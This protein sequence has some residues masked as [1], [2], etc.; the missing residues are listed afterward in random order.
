MKYLYLFFLLLAC[1]VTRAQVTT[2]YLSGTIKTSKGKLAGGTTIL[3]TNTN[4]GGVYNSL[5]D[6][7]GNYTIPNLKPGGPYRID[8]SFK[9]Y[10]PLGLN[11]VIV[12]ITTPLKIDIVLNANSKNVYYVIVNGSKELV[13]KT[14]TAGELVNVTLKDLTY[15]PV[16]GGSFQDFAR[17]TPQANPI[18]STANNG[19]LGAS[20]LGQNTKYNL[21]SIDGIKAVNVFGLYSGGANVNPI[22]Q[23]SI[24]SLQV[25]LNPYDVFYGRFLGGYLSATTKSGTNYLHGEGY[26]YFQDQQLV[27]KSP[28]TGLNYPNFINRVLGASLGGPV[29]KNKLFFFADVENS[30]YSSPVIYDPTQANA[31]SKFDPTVLQGLHDY[32]EKQYGFD[33]GSY[34]GINRNISSTSAFGRLD[35][36]IDSKN[37][38]TLRN[39]YVE[40]RNFV[41]SRAPTSLTFSNDGYTVNIKTNSTVLEL[42]SSFSNDLS[43]VFRAG[44][45]YVNN[46][47]GTSAFPS[48]NITEGGLIYNLG[49]DNS[50]AANSL[51]QKDFNLVDYFNIYKGR[52]TLSFGTDNELYA[53]RSVF[54]QNYNG[55]YTY[56]SVAAFESGAA[57]A[58]YSVGYSTSGGTDKAPAVMR[59]A[60]LA[61]YS[62]DV[63][64]VNDR[65]KL[66][67]GIRVDMPVFLNSPDNNPAFNS[68]S[69]A[70]ANGVAT[71]RTPKPA[72]L[73]SPR[74]GFNY[75]L[76]GNQTTQLRGGAGVFTG[77]VPYVW[78]ANQYSNSGTRSISFTGVP[79]GLTFNYNPNAPHL[80]AYIPQNLSQTPTEIDVTDPDFKLPQQFHANVAVNQKLPWGMAGTFE[81]FYSKTI[82][83]VL[84]KN[85]N[86]GSPQNTLTLGNTTRPFYNYSY[87]DNSYTDVIEL[88]NT[89]KGYSYDLTTQLIKR[90]TSGWLVMGAYT[91]GHSYSVND[92]I[93]PTAVGNW[94][95][96]YTGDD[97]NDPGE[98]S[99]NFDLGSRVVSYISKTFSKP[100]RRFST[101]IGILYSGQL[102]QAYSYLYNYNINGDGISNKFVASDLV[103][104]PTDASQFVGFTRVVNGANKIITPAQQLTDLQAF[105]ADN[106]DLQ[107]YNGQSTP[108]NG[109]RLPW[110]NHVDLRVTESIITF[111]K[112]QLQ[113]GLSLLNAANIVNKDWG[114]VY[115][116]ANQEYNLFNVSTTGTDPKFTFDNSK[117]STVNGHLRAYSIDDYNSRW[118]GQL[119][120]NYSF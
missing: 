16:A 56:K 87:L 101:I 15:F 119:N 105:L 50:S 75:D 113:V 48:I 79:A 13:D 11:N 120:L 49:G 10:H 22:P 84:Y 110:E 5:I 77:D 29:I 64:R 90:F 93:G 2:C 25:L 52:H 1:F 24:Q 18:R 53:L 71:N 59:V 41:I 34:S 78:I 40:G 4:T 98:S 73:F 33:I 7:A 63:W 44:Y 38:L 65:L 27:G 96:A 111:K 95:S 102:G 32:V 9:G 26:G 112:Q 45:N 86:L 74:G 88:T 42:N 47:R 57:P 43:N 51:A 104:I 118:R 6:T 106:K 37:K 8:F 31:G 58:N 66:T 20:Y 62:Q 3:A 100:N 19:L 39:S 21:L 115:Y 70:T 81:A 80:G 117:L 94:R 114:R 54:L 85:L 72:P 108:R 89:N 91:Y 83:D 61:V 107:K 28:I 99:S 36:D 109:F 67:Y 92:G 97:L 82:T 68:S 23:Q 103:Y 14:E 17:F 69:I 46:V 116:I 30:Q 60:Q 55:Y 12:S 76:F 35:W